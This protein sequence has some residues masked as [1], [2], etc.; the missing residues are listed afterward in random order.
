MK[1]FETK[2]SEEDKTYLRLGD[3]LFLRSAIGAQR[4]QFVESLNEHEVI[5]LDNGVKKK[6]NYNN[7]VL[8]QKHTEDIS[9]ML[10]LL[11]ADIQK[12]EYYMPDVNEHLMCA[13][14][15]PTK[16][17]L[18]ILRDSLRDASTMSPSKEVNE[19]KVYFE[20]YAD[21]ITTLGKI[22]KSKG[23]SMGM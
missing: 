12:R 5:V 6:T 9:E 18:T 21:K 14:D 20:Y 15:E 2:L 7:L 4:Y 8:V 16:R 13:I 3:E 19:M 17:N 1:E 10:E 23:I 22:D 11:F